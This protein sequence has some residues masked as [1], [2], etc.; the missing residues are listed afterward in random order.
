M[1]DSPPL[2]LSLFQHFIIIKKKIG[3]GGEGLLSTGPIQPHQG[4]IPVKLKKK[5][6]NFFS[7]I[8]FLLVISILDYS[9]IFQPFPAYSRLFHNSLAYSSLFKPIPETCHCQS[10]GYMYNMGIKLNKYSID[11]FWS[12]KHIHIG[13]L[14]YPKKQNLHIAL[15]RSPNI[16]SDI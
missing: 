1:S 15:C 13:S 9:S 14:T 4:Q 6:L 10:A 8:F 16:N 7:S 12:I 2:S 5:F 11:F 3:R